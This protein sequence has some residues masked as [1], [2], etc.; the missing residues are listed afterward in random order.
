[1]TV[2]VWSVAV[3]QDRVETESGVLWCSDLNIVSRR[4]ESC[5]RQR[6]KHC[7]ALYPD[8][9]ALRV[10]LSISL[11]FSYFTSWVASFG[12]FKFVYCLF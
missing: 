10:G 7:G 1:M 3:L 12:C 8:A 4:C 9:V 5:W 6:V 2:Y 11:P